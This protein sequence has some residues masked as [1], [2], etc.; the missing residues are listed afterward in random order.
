MKS[1]GSFR[2]ARRRQLG[3]LC[4]LA[5]VPLLGLTGCGRLANR[6]PA[7]AVATAESPDS[8]NAPERPQQS[9]NPLSSALLTDLT[10]AEPTESSVYDADGN[11]H[12][13]ESGLV[14]R[15][16]SVEKVPLELAGPEPGR[17]VA[18]EPGERVALIKVTVSVQND[19]PVAAS[20]AAKRP[21]SVVAR[22]GSASFGGPAETAAVVTSVVP[23]SLRPQDTVEIYRSFQLPEDKLADLTIETS[24]GSQTPHTFHDVALPWS[25][26]AA[27]QSATASAVRAAEGVPAPRVYTGQGEKEFTIAKPGG[28]GPALLAVSAPEGGFFMGVDASGTETLSIGNPTGAFTSV[29]A[30]DLEPGVET[31]SITS[32]AAGQWSVAVRPLAAARQFADATSGAGND[33][34]LYT[35][36]SGMSIVTGE[37]ADMYRHPMIGDRLAAQAQ[38]PQVLYDGVGVR[39]NT[40]VVVRASGPWTLRVIAD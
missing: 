21:I 39:M 40:L 4:V 14:V 12:R 19:S 25:A 13:Y 7:S 24:V 28:P 11:T 18:F 2:R 8:S 27:S 17:A 22:S 23:T 38:P 33:V 3:A 15:L 1:G 26:T 10:D 30:I 5:L 9:P 6:L 20:L 36:P 34:L 35:G 32:M 37:G 16:V 29:E 31:T